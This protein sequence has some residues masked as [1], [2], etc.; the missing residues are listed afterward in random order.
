[1]MIQKVIIGL[2]L[3]LMLPLWIPVGIHTEEKNDLEPGWLSLD[4]IIGPFDKKVEDTKSTLR[5]ALGIN[6]RAFLD[7][8]YTYSFNHPGSGSNREISLRDFDRDHN[9]VVFNDFHLS[10]EKPEQDW[11]VGLNLS[12]D[13]GRAAEILRQSTFWGTRQSRGGAAELREAFLTSTIPI[14]QGL[15]V[16]GGW[17]ESPLGMEN[18]PRPGAYNDNISRSFLFNFAVP[19]RHL[20]LLLTYPVHKILSLSAGPV[21]GWDMVGDINRQPSFLSSMVL[22]PNEVFSWESS[23][24][25][26]PEQKHR[27]GPKRLAWSNVFT[28]EPAEPLT[29][30]LEHTYGHEE[31][32]TASLRGGTWQ[33]CP[34]LLPTTGRIGLPQPLE[35][36]FSMIGMVL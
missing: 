19:H 4:K 36:S 7:V 1:M 16:R 24:I 27:S 12:A 5:K 31:K 14:G 10:L 26:G 2:V 3:F 15:K 33:A 6:I 34:R 29:L 13:F 22:S 21:T 20:G 9:K 28:V 17:F 32:V 35:E 11:G 23:F 18:L 25:I 8:S 30:S